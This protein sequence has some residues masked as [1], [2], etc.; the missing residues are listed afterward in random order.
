MAV[1]KVP[2]LLV[3]L[4]FVAL[5]G[6]GQKVKYKDLIEL[7]NTNQFDQAEP[8]LRRYLKENDDNPS[9]YMYMGIILQGKALATDMLRETGKAAT[10][11]DS[12][13]LFINKAL[14][15]ITEREVN[16][17]E[18]NYLRYRS[19]D[20]RTG[21]FEIKFTEVRFRLEQDVKNLAIRKANIHKLRLEFDAFRRNYEVA[22]NDFTKLIAASS[23]QKEFYLRADETIEAQL[24]QLKI[25][26]DSAL[27][28]FAAYQSTTQ[29]IGKTGYKHILDKKDVV[30]Y[31]E[32]GKRDFNLYSDDLKVW[33]YGTWAERSAS[34]IKNEVYPLR[35]KF[36]ATDRE[37]VKL[38]RSI[39]KD[40]VSVLKE[41]T[42]LYPKLLVNP[43][44]QYDANPMPLKVFR[45]THA[46]LSYY[47]K[48]LE[49][50]K[51]KQ[52]PNLLQ[53]KA[54]YQS[55]LPYLKKLD[56][57][58]G[59]LLALDIDQEAINYQNYVKTSYGSTL[60]LKSLISSTHDFAK[61][62]SERC[63]AALNRLDQSLKWLVVQSDSIPL[64]MPVP[65]EAPIQPLVVAAET[66]THGIKYPQSGAPT[67]Y[68]YTITPE[69]LPEVQVLYAVDSAFADR[70]NQAFFK[71]LATTDGK[72][73]LYYTAVFSEA[74]NAAGKFPVTI[75]KIYRTDG[76]AWQMN[77]QLDA[78]PAELQLNATTGELLVRGTLNGESRM[79]VIDKAGKL[80]Q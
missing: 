55:E 15:G 11:M 39:E 77:Y 63:R 23:S 45:M 1:K 79:F 7:L 9:A 47:S 49:N 61:R 78:I 34:F 26:F 62:E 12:A 70:R 17:N 53:R 74:R 32:D 66:F 72:G 21:E 60:V 18:E 48:W 16:R 10:Y 3:A 29:Q 27:W 36:L 19:R 35:E 50:K 69:R 51:T 46:E 13:S 56:S 24:A 75:C 59:L 65:P 5:P 54:A 14:E 31:G 28:Y 44:E 80:L 40:S 4:A 73:Q 68:F 30:K 41:L 2:F 43:V 20:V 37:L 67:G 64:A 76:L 52:G 38:R 42:D 33:D 58:S 25:R 6:W 8:H 71:A 22:K 57:I